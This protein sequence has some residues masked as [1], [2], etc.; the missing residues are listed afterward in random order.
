MNNDERKFYAA[1]LMELGAALRNAMVLNETEMGPK[2][3]ELAFESVAQLIDIEKMTIAPT[4]Q[5]LEVEKQGL[6]FSSAFLRFGNYLAW[7]RG[8]DLNKL[9][10]D[11]DTE[12]EAGKVGH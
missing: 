10:S 8:I 5:H 3:L 9:V 7:S 11:G 6:F 12:S 1:L 2:A 4:F